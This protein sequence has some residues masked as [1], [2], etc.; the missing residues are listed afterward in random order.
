MIWGIPKS[1][2]GIVI[3][4]PLRLTL[5]VLFLIAI[6]AGC[7]KTTEIVTL[8]PPATVTQAPATK[9]PLKPTA[10]QVPAT[11]TLPPPTDTSVIPTQTL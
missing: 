4:K 11:K 9:T 1:K 7:T 3:R 2:G 8:P 10:T 5:Y 6:L